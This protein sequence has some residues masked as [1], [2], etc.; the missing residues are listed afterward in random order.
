MMLPGVD[1]TAKWREG[2][3]LIYL[4]QSELWYRH[5]KNADNVEAEQTGLYIFNQYG[6]NPSNLIG[7]RL[8]AYKDLS[9][10]NAITGKK[11][12]NIEYGVAPEFTW[13][14]SEFVTA[15][16]GLSHTFTREEGMTTAKDTRIEFQFVF[17]L[18]A[19]PAHSF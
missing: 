1:F 15:R 11:Q 5:Q 14:S 18:G 16:T 4:F 17:I 2:K 19:H 9:K 10:T 7:L 3:R 6:I 13:K 12:N 8:D